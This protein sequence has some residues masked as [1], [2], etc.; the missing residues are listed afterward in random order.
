VDPYDPAIVAAIDSLLSQT[1]DAALK[2]DADRVTAIAADSLTFV[3]GDVILAGL[4]PIR[5]RFRQTYSHLERQ[6]QTVVEKRIRVL[7]P[8]VVVAIV[9]AE[10]TYTDR[11]GWTS[12]PVGLGTTIVFVR[13]NGQWRAQ[14]VH[15]S[16]MP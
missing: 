8:D 10:G 5:E 14:H 16:V 13:E 7:S 15:Q 6:N 9:T 4:E 12:P 2:V 3:T 11:A 1:L